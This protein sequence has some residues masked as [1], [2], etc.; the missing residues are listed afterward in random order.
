VA[1]HRSA[2]KR[3]RQINTRRERNRSVLSTLKTL[4]KKVHSAIDQKK[5]DDAQL[6]LVTVSS[7][8]GKAVSKGYVHRNT[9]ARKVS[10]LT[11]KV[12]SLKGIEKK[13]TGSSGK[14]KKKEA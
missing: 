14:N 10:R 7:A 8:L 2:L 5:V 1:I 6:C 3:E 4:I 9:A 12:N 13:G 11:L